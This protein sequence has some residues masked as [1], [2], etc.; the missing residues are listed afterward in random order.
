MLLTPKFCHY[1]KHHNFHLIS[2]CGNFAERQ[3]FGGVSRDSLE[4]EKTV[5]TRNFHTRI[6]V[7]KLRYVCSVMY[8]TWTPIAR[9]RIRRQPYRNHYKE[10]NYQLLIFHKLKVKILPSLV[11]FNTFFFCVKYGQIY[12]FKI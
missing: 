8:G 12:H 6:L 9:M 7:V 4:T 5:F 2:W 11:F 10:S 3:T 1:G